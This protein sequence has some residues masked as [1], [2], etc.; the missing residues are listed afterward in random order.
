MLSAEQ[1][2]GEI[3]ASWLAERWGYAPTIP[4]ACWNDAHELAERLEQM[5]SHRGVGRS[6]SKRKPWRAWISGPNGVNR[7]LGS[8]ATKEE[9]VVARQAA[10]ADRDLACE[11]ATTMPA[12]GRTN[13]VEPDQAFPDTKVCRRCSVPVGQPHKSHGWADYA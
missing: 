11:M 9:A 13:L 2:R 10:E 4:E 12:P 6:Y 8:F 5:T 7:H 1:R 3:I